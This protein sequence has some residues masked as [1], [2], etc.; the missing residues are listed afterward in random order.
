MPALTPRQMSMQAATA[1]ATPA[2]DAALC[3]PL[4]VKFPHERWLYM[5]GGCIA[6]AMFLFA[7]FFAKDRQFLEAAVLF[8][9]GLGLVAALIA[10]LLR[11]RQ[12][13]PVLC[14]YPD[15]LV[16]RR[17]GRETVCRYDRIRGLRFT[18]KRFYSDGNLK[19]LKLRFAVWDAGNFQAPP[20]IGVSGWVDMSGEKKP[21]SAA[22]LAP[23]QDRIAQVMCERMGKG[24]PLAGEGFS[25]DG[26][27]LRIGGAQVAA[28]AI[29]MAGVFNHRACLW[30]GGRI[31]PA[32][33]L[34]L[35]AVNVLP[36]LAAIQ[37]QLQKRS[38]PPQ[39]L[40]GLG[41][42]LTVMQ[43]RPWARG[44]LYFF[45]VF[46]LLEAVLIMNGMMALNSPD[47]R[48][49]MGVIPLVFG[50]PLLLFALSAETTWFRVYEN[51]VAKR[52]WWRKITLPY[53][54]VESFSFDTSQE[55]E[56]AGKDTGM[57]YA[58]TRVT[59]TFAS[60]NGGEVVFVSPLRRQ[61]DPRLD[62]VRDYVAQVLGRKLLGCVQAGKAV[63]WGGIGITRNGLI[64]SSGTLP[65]A[66][67]AG[68][69][70]Q[71][72]TFRML[73]PGDM[74]DSILHCGAAN[75]Y[76]GLWVF[77][78]LCPAPETGA[79]GKK[80]VR[81]EAVASLLMEQPSLPTKKGKH[82]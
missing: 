74:P 27:T 63:K 76:P 39:P 12:R 31:R 60:K 6:G 14:F 47:D 23:V 9:L 81:N 45:A 29:E 30:T 35:A 72:D 48:L 10:G 57:V 71:E 41:R 53:D 56:Y 37:E 52:R 18:Q 62:E 21:L 73:T 36:L 5:S 17:N 77:S 13:R 24:E 80:T 4:A 51:G 54:A 70:F 7:Y 42:L 69:S 28:D 33:R 82:A 64:L 25:F 66:D 50:A 2:A 61:R 44:L 1:A 75:F 3:P 65:F 40:P 20:V 67:I 46:F 8:S 19:G 22:G 32:Y 15:H 49:V 55:E 16:C 43:M 38:A 79:A 78:R 58:G 26:A 59:M 68:V 34:P 11:C